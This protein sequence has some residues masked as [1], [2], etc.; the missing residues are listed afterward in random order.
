VERNPGDVLFS[1]FSFLVPILVFKFN[2]RL[3]STLSLECELQIKYAT[4]R[5][6]MY[7]SHIYLSVYYFIYLDKCI[8]I[9]NPYKN[10]FLKSICEG[11]SIYSMFSV[12]FT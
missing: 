4:Q 5:S 9:H 1:L 8:E 10:N 11:R 2:F 3:F 7:A 12:C 6:S